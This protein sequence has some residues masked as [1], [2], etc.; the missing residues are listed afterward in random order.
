MKYTLILLMFVSACDIP[1]IPVMTDVKIYTDVSTEDSRRYREDSMVTIG[2][3]K[4]TTIWLRDQE[5]SV[6]TNFPAPSWWR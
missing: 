4:D 3:E 5:V 1:N 2:P 6:T